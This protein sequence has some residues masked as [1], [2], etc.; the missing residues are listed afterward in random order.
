[1]LD[2][3]PTAVKKYFHNLAQKIVDIKNVCPNSSIVVNPL[4]PTRSQKLNQRVPE[5]NSN[6]AV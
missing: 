4:L 1:M 6:V 3:Q 5:F 2:P